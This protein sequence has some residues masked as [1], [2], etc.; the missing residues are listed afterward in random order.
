MDVLKF[1]AV[2]IGFGFFCIVWD[3]A[4][5]AWG[6]GHGQVLLIFLGIAFVGT[7][8]VHSLVASGWWIFPL[9]LVDK[10]RARRDGGK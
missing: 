4:A 8:V 3:L 1:F 7:I 2:I 5:A 10:W 9:W 6:L